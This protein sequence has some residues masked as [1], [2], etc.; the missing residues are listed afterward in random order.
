MGWSHFI[1]L[2]VYLFTWLHRV[3]VAACGTFVEAHGIFSCS[4][5]ELVPC[6]GSNLG[7]L[8]WERGVLV[9]RPPG[10]SRDGLI[11]KNTGLD[12]GKPKNYIRGSGSGTIFIPDI[13]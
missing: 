12:T 9:T 5:C 6:Q 11:L 2:F 3:L 7:P 10:K 4:M 1:Y 8:H 13:S